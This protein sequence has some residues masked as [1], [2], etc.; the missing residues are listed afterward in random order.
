MKTFFEQTQEIVK[1]NN[2]VASK[3][4]A[5][6]KLGLREIDVNNLLYT[7]ARE[8]REQARAKRVAEAIINS[9]TFGVEIECYNAASSIIRERAAANNL[10][11]AYESYNHRDNNR[12]F[13]F[14]SDASIQGAMPIECVSPVLKGKS[15]FADLKNCCKTLNEAGVRV[16]RSTGLHVHVGGIQTAKQYINVFKNYKALERVIDTFMAESRRGN[17]SQWCRTLSDHNFDNC[18]SI[19]D[20]RNVLG[21]D[22]YHRV[23]AESWSRHRTIEFRQHAG[24]T[25]FEKIQMWV[26]FCIK[27]VVWSAENVITE[28]INTIQDIPFLSDKEKAYFQTRANEFAGVA[29]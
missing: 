16:N 22:R 7:Y 15:G 23:N 13:K 2:S 8:E 4:R 18:L 12:Y 19:D 14:T 24:S 10:N 1:S 6:I 26:T 9:L 25:N 5:L 17:N 28:T 3:K 21:C 20:V 27:L 11:I 29:A